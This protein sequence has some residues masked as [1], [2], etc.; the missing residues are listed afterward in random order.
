MNYEE[1]QE[2]LDS[3][4][5]FGIKLGLEN[6]QA[7]CR[8]LGNPEKD[9]KFIHVAGTNG[10]GSCCAMLAAALKNVRLKVG[11]YSSPF[12]YRFTERWRINGHEVTEEQVAQAVFE[13]SKVEKALVKITGVRPT[14]FE[15]LTAAALL[16]FRDEKVDV[17]VWETGMGGRLDATNCV[18]PLV[19][20][21]TNIGYDHMQYL[22]NSLEEIA[23]EKGGIIKPSTPLVCGEEN[24]DL[25][26]IFKSIAQK[27]NADIYLY[28]KDFDYKDFGLSLKNGGYVRDIVYFSQFRQSVK[29]VLPALGLHQCQNISLAV[30]VLEIICEKVE[31][32]FAKA[33]SGIGSYKW[34]GRLELRKN[35]LILDGAHNP[36]GAKVLVEALT[37]LYPNK[38]FHFICGILADKNWRD[39]LDILESKATSFYL[40]KINNERAE[41]TKKL[42][43]YLEGKSIK[44][45]GEGDI[46]QALDSIESPENS[47]VVG[48]L[49]LI[50]E[51]LAILNNYEPAPVDSLLF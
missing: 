18:M 38:K 41:N 10:K 25:V 50:G 3:L 27:N 17:V 46:S 15:V 42:R 24:S 1:A 2:Y 40:V 37:E 44:V 43:E 31:V 45:S 51:A 36:A 19:S 7:L 5:I 26:E 16:I 29:L 22:G 33:V 23:F 48:S 35:G 28:R 11:F 14:Y 12:L 30:K 8:L 13:I 9:L 32:D 34:P 39:I 21:I 49:Y 20:V 47:V 4:L 6:M